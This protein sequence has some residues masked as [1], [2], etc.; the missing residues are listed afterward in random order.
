VLWVT[1][2]VAGAV[3]PSDSAAHPRAFRFSAAKRVGS[4]HNPESQTGLPTCPIVIPSC[5]TA[6][7]EA[8]RTRQKLTQHCEGNAYTLSYD[9]TACN[10][11][12]RSRSLSESLQVSYEQ[13]YPLY[14]RNAGSTPFSR[15]SR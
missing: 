1:G 7:H 15:S 12:T 4:N 10:T 11:L 8:S 3:V 9:L 13:I 2:E 5:S 6:H 14:T